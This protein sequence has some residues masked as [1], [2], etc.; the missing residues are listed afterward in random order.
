MQATSNEKHSNLR[1]HRILHPV[2]IG[3]NATGANKPSPVP[4]SQ[5]STLG[6]HVV[7]PG[8]TKSC[9]FLTLEPL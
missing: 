4:N 9:G 6:V 8:K 7:V 5:S 1:V 2:W 3:P